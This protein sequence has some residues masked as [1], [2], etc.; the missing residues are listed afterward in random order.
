M[1]HVAQ[2]PDVLKNGASLT[3]RDGTVLKPTFA[4]VIPRPGT[5]GVLFEFSRDR[6]I[7]LGD[8]TVEFSLAASDFSV[9]ARFKLKDMMFRGRLEL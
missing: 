2:E 8:K 4:E 3:L 7:V 5:P 9:R 1:A 6:E